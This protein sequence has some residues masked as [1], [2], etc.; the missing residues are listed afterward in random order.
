M[1]KKALLFLAALF[2]SSVVS[3]AIQKPL[4]VGDPAPAFS[5]PGNDG[6]TYSLKDYA[7]KKMVLYFYPK[8]Q[9]PG[10]TKEACAFRDR[11][12]EIKAQGAAVF[13]INADSVK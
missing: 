1:S 8:D 10:C 6:K 13:G 4:A 2:G 3:A 11:N 5:L 7:G 9:T 12:E